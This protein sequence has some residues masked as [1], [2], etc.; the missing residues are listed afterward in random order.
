MDR[1]SDLIKSE[2]PRTAKAAQDAARDAEHSRAGQPKYST[3]NSPRGKHKG[4]TRGEGGVV[5]HHAF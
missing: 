2:L 5:L 3:P 1:M 4:E